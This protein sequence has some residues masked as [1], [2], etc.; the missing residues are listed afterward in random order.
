MPLPSPTELR[1]MLVQ[2]VFQSEALIVAQGK[3]TPYMLELEA[4]KAADHV[5]A[6]AAAN[7]PQTQPPTISDPDPAAPALVEKLAGVVKYF[8]AND[9]A[10]LITARFDFKNHFAG[11]LT[12]GVLVIEPLCDGIFDAAPAGDCDYPTLR[13]LGMSRY[14]EP[15]GIETLGKWVKSQTYRSC[16]P[17]GDMADDYV[18]CVTLLKL[19][20]ELVGGK[21]EWNEMDAC[22]TI[23]R[24]RI[25]DAKTTS[26]I[27]VAIGSTYSVPN[28][29]RRGNRRFV[30]SESNVQ[31]ALEAI[32]RSHKYHPAREWF[33]NLPKWDGL[34]HF[35]DLL[36]AIGGQRD[37]TGL[38]GEPLKW[39]LGTNALALSQ[40]MKTFIGSVARTFDPGC[41]MD[42]MWVL[43]SKQ[44]TKKSS[45]FEALTPAKRFSDTHIDFGSKDSRMTFVQNSWIEIAELSSMQRKE[46]GLVK[47]EITSKSDDFRLPFGKHMTKNPRWCILVGSTND[48]TFL[49]DGTGSRRFWIIVIDDRKINIAYVE[50]IVP[51]LW[52][53]ALHIYRGATGC[54]DCKAGI[55]G[56]TR[57]AAH[58]WW[59]SL[60]EDELR[61][62]FNQQFTEEEPYVDLVKAFLQNAINDKKIAK[63]G[64]HIKIQ[65]TDCF[66]I[67]EALEDIAGLKGKE[68]FDMLQQR[69]MAFALKVNGYIKKHTN[70]GNMW[71]SPTMASRPDLSIVPPPPKDDDTKKQDDVVDAVDPLKTPSEG[72]K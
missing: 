1:E 6:R 39:A 37:V 57:C 61:E 45:L 20:S 2:T 13:K 31:Q 54:P 72:S 71:I 44:G 69:R 38:S 65:N 64:M 30:P 60:E 16:M 52:A 53:Q 66:R 34:D 67:H 33:E 58:R 23:N 51:Q 17:N 35:A 41:K 5:A 26:D 70:A 19:D 46:V 59:L 56:E 8:C 24:V 63:Q 36:R 32:A 9:T 50:S 48:D 49:K 15:L 43:K 22:I 18:S 42:T 25:E 55:D 7:L 11:V 10:L 3:K 40:T 28:G 62:K 12:K 47:Q 27:R 21:L 4:Q 68:C 14:G 29:G